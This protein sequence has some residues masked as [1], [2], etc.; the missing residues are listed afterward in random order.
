MERRLIDDFLLTAKDSLENLGHLVR[1]K[2]REAEA[3]RKERE[4]KKQKQFR[5]QQA[6]Q[7]KTDLCSDIK[8]I[9]KNNI[10]F[11]S[12]EAIAIPECDYNAEASIW[13]LTVETLLKTTHDLM[14]ARVVTSLNDSTQ[15]YFRRLY[16]EY[17]NEL[18]ELAKAE[19]S[20][21][22][23]QNKLNIMRFQIDQNYQL[24]IHELYFVSVKCE[25][26]GEYSNV[27][28]FARFR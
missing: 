12:V 15:V 6:N 19:C 14:R 26:N 20:P 18:L 2:N 13:E 17:R 4:Q 24:L 7:I 16:L 22:A 21:T 27:K 5:T 23:E 25:K 9:L 10:Y 3:K 8:T 11:Q 1:E 28:I